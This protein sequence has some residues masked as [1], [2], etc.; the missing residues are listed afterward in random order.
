MTRAKVVIGANF[1]DEG[2][3]VMT[4]YLSQHAVASPL[5]VLF[6]G[7]AQRGHTAQTPDGFRHVFHHF[8]SGTLVGART[9]LSHHFISNPVLFHKERAEI[10]DFAP[11]IFADLRG[12]FTT[13]YDMIINQ[14]VE[15]VRGV[16]RHGS[17]GLGIN[18]TIKRDEAGF[19]TNLV[20]L[21]DPSNLSGSLCNIRENWVPRRFAE[22]GINPEDLADNWKRILASDRLIVNFVEDCRKFLTQV[23][24][25]NETDLIAD[26]E[27]VIFE[28]GQGLLLDEDHRYFPHVTHSH[29]GLFN[30]AEL[31][32]AAR[33]T[34][35]EVFYMT[36][37]YAT[38]H[39]AGPFETE[40]DKPT[41][42]VEDATNIPNMYQ[43]TL[44]FGK[45]DTD[46]LKESITTDLARAQ[47]LNVTASVVVTCLDQANEKIETKQKTVYKT[48]FLQNLQ[49]D[50]GIKISHSSYGPS[51]DKVVTFPRGYTKRMLAIDDYSFWP[52]ETNS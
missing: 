2:K 17:C 10:Q 32:R 52:A 9:L 35:L 49:S 51:R 30:V 5:N 14:I 19:T 20:D 22:L 18:E 16:N 50:L 7:G 45:L 33:V 8:G 41:D 25:A 15:E 36:R 43:G 12:R 39:G 11:M 31:L 26:S 42:K 38:R 48:S 3:G 1:G 34:D 4:D 29:T 23:L 28:A 6:N 13:P 21:L 46:L 44:R 27:D 47:D 37:W 24:L 40:G